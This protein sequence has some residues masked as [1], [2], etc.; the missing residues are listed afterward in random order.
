[1][2]FDQLFQILVLLGLP[3]VWPFLLA[4]YISKKFFV[5]F[6]PKLFLL[7]SA[8]G[9]SILILFCALAFVFNSWLVSAGYSCNAPNAANSKILC[10]K[11]FLGFSNWYQSY[12]IYLPL[13]VS[14]VTTTFLFKCH[15]ARTSI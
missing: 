4:L 2:E 8:A 15:A 9:Y 12:L 6:K 3:L 10:S 11:P 7:Y 1:M 13:W 5:V 14:L